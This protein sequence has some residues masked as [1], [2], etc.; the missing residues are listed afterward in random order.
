[1]T[2]AS[3]HGFAS[4]RGCQR[5]ADVRHLSHFGKFCPPLSAAAI[6]FRPKQTWGPGAY[7]CD[8]LHKLRRRTGCRRVG[9]CRRRAYAVARN[10][11]LSRSNAIWAHKLR[12]FL[13]LLGV[14]FGVAAVIVVVS[15]I[16]GFNAY[17]DEKIADIGTNAFRGAEVRDRRLL[18]PRPLPESHAAQPGRPDGRRRGDSRSSRRS[19]TRS[20]YGR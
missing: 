17:I 8:K 19:S 3:A 16:E 9:I 7:Y 10:R 2:R 13:T 4:A 5:T 14:I 18:G 11:S 1:M 20:A 6:E 15:L 12:S